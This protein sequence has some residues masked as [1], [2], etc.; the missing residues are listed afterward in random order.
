MDQRNYAYLDYDSQSEHSWSN[1]KGYQN[2]V[3]S[4][5]N[6]DGNINTK[7]KV[8]NKMSNTKVHNNLIKNNIE[9]FINLNSNK[10]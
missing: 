9:K 10:N 7:N 1:V 4:Q 2:M 3:I 8:W 5:V 6:E